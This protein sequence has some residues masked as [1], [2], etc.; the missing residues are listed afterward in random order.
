MRLA[1]RWPERVESVAL[2]APAGISSARRIGAALVTLAGVVRPARLLSTQANRIANSTRLRRLVFGS[3][4]VSNPDL[5][6]ERAVHGFLQGAALHTD[7]L[8]AGRALVADDPFAYLDHVRCPLLVLFGGRDAQVPV[9]DG[10]EYA[11]R[12]GAP[13]RVIADCGHLLIGERPEICARVALG[14]STGGV[15]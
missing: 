6:D 1:A 13:F 12:L 10:I 15:G 8:G 9:E 2:A 7:V 4:E 5:L 14:F 3:L 11:R